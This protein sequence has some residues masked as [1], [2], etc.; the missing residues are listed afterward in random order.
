MDVAV[1]ALTL[2]VG[3][4]TLRSSERRTVVL[5]RGARHPP[6]SRWELEVTGRSLRAED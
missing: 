6:L 1:L 2:V 5:N 4:N 3:V